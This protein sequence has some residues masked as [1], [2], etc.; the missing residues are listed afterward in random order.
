MKEIMSFKKGLTALAVM[1]MALSA[2][3]AAHAGEGV[4]TDWQM[5]FQSAVTPVMHDIQEFHDLLLIIITV[6]ALF[7]TVLL[8][9]AMF[10][11]SEK[12]N[13]VPSKTTHNTLLEVAW[14]VIPV[15]ILVVIAIPSFKLLYFQDKA[16][17]P[18]M[19][20]K[21][22]G[23]QW[24]WS[25]EYPDHGDFTFDSIM[26]ADEDIEGNQVRLLSTD[27]AVVVPEDTEIRLL[28]TASDVIHAWAIPSFGVKM[29]AVPG[30]VNETWFRSPKLSDLTQKTDDGALFYGQCSELC[31]VNHGFMPIEVKVV[32]KEAYAKW[33]EFA[34]EEFASA[35]DTT[36]QVAAVTANEPK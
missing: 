21:A 30:R 16:A 7:V 22:I 4:P 32:T 8:G 28:V 15:I 20:I 29:D 14:T 2:G 10:R 36:R 23:H 24:Y 35:D 18:E 1:T 31:G 25:Y 13:P 17:N 19:T 3:F 5:G 33:L 26:V 27:N 6:I 9:Y 34:K 11:F 12:R